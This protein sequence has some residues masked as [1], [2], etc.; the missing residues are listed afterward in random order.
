[1]LLHASFPPEEIDKERGVI[2]E[3]ERM[4]QD[5]PMYRAG[6]DFEEL[7]YGDT[8]LGWD[9]IGT[10]EVIMS[11]KQ[12][13]FQKHKDDLYGP[14]NCVVAFSGKI[15][16]QEAMA[17]ATEFFG[18]LGGGSKR[19]FEPLTKYGPDRMLIRNKNTEQS[20]LVFGVPGLSSQHEDHFVHKIL[21]IILGGNMSSR[22]FLRIREA[23]GLCYYISSETDNYMDAGALTT[24]AGVDQSRLLEA[25]EA[26]KHEYLLCAD[27]GIEQDELTRAKAFLKGKITLSLEDSEERAHYYGKQLL[28]YP[29]VRDINEYFAEVDKV[30][31]E[32]VDALAKRILLPE[33]LRLVVI[34]KD[35][36]PEKFESLMKA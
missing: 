16:E 4:Y 6:W 24:S 36:T 12:A 21:A 20:H 5:T 35:A 22:M 26:I 17:L 31:K 28:L 10:E 8:P 18:P 32:Q 13:D 27:K 19:T 2:M 29:K 7:L 30:T 15:T 14:H 34:G 23:R 1:M 9:T 11:V 3:E 33:E 25:L